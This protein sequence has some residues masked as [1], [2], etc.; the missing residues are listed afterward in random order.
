MSVEYVDVK[1]VVNVLKNLQKLSYDASN[2][3]KVNISADNVGLAKDTTLQSQLPR[4]IYGYTGTTWVPLKV[5]SEGKVVG[6]LG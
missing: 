6:V 5:T 3:L 4:R 1:L 2:N